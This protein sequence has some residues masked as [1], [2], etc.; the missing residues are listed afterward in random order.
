MKKMVLFLMLGFSLLGYFNKDVLL[1]NIML[2]N[3]PEY[4]QRQDFFKNLSNE[5]YGSDE[6]G[7]ELESVNRKFKIKKDESNK[8]N[9]IIPNLEA[10]KRLKNKQTLLSYENKPY[11][12]IVYNHQQRL[13][14]KSKKDIVEKKQFLKSSLSILILIVLIL[15]MILSLI[16]YFWCRQHYR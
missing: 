16:R 1:N 9:L 4:L 7:T 2:K 11:L 3:R 15:S 6:F 5:F 10:I 8:L 12:K 13:L 14:E